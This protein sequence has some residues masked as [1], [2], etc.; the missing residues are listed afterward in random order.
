MNSVEDNPSTIVTKMS[1][2]GYF[3]DYCPLRPLAL[4]LNIA[5]IGYFGYNSEQWDKK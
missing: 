3:K 5:K 2:F 4:D 1:K